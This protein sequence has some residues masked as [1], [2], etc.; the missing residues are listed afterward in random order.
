MRHL[1]LF[2]LLLAAL[3]GPI[4]AS[5]ALALGTALRATFVAMAEDSTRWGAQ[6]ARAA[7][8]QYAG[9]NYQDIFED[10]EDLERVDT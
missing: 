5:A 2:G 1:L 8:N 7:L 6:A 3:F 9:T 10:G 4:R